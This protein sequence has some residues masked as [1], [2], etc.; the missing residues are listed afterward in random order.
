MFCIHWD[1]YRSYGLL[2]LRV[3]IGLLFI[4]HGYPK[5]MGGPVFWTQIGGAMGTIG[6][7]F[8]PAFWGFMAA[9]SEFFGGIL[10][11]VGFMVR[12]AS[13]LLA[14]TMVM[15]ALHHITAG[16]PFGHTAHPIKAL[17]IFIALALCGPGKYA[18]D[19]IF[20]KQE[21]PD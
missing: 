16:D 4:I 18:V 8:L 20:R 6:I 7:T 19:N 1:K 11:V 13:L 15:A 5:I 21:K 10:L 3:G 14:F 2:N 12:P 17:L 9:F